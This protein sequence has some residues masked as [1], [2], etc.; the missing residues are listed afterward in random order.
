MCIRDRCWACGAGWHWSPTH[1]RA[2]RLGMCSAMRAGFAARRAGGASWGTALLRRRSRGP[3]RGGRAGDSGG[4]LSGLRSG[5]CRG[6]FLCLDRDLCP[7]LDRGLF[8]GPCDC[9][10]CYCSRPRGEGWQR[11]VRRYRQTWQLTCR[12]TPASD[13][14]C[15]SSLLLVDRLLCGTRGCESKL[16]QMFASQAVLRR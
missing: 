2:R 4:A 7:A 10:C 3:S 6:L 15:P 13:A 8:P 12:V 9:L 16:K 11:C 14:C 5:L 1:C